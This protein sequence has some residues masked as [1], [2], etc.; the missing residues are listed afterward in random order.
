MH[1]FLELNDGDSNRFGKFIAE[2]FAKNKH[3]Y[4]HAKGFF[5]TAPFYRTF[6]ERNGMH[7]MLEEILMTLDSDQ[8]ALTIEKHFQQ[9]RYN[10]DEILSLRRFYYQ[11]EKPIAIKAHIVYHSTGELLSEVDSKFQNSIDSFDQF[12]DAIVSMWQRCWQAKTLSV[13]KTCTAFKKGTFPKLDVVL[14][15]SEQRALEEFNEK[16]AEQNS[17]DHNMRESV[18]WFHKIKRWIC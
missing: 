4:E 10:M 1:W 3:F 7:G 15:V 9:S 11:L 5:V 18:K 16:Q 6:V 17:L 12:S 14:I 13:L 2:E 8:G